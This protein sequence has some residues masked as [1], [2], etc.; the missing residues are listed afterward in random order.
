MTDRAFFALALD[1]LARRIQN[2]HGEDITGFTDHILARI[3]MG[4]G[5]YGDH[6]YLERD[7]LAE[8][9]DEYADGISYP[10]FEL[11]KLR[12]AGQPIP[13]EVAA[14]LTDAMACSAQ[15]HLKVRQAR[16][17]LHSSDQ[18]SPVQ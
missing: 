15:A 6:A 9:S 14:L 18:P 3:D 16:R 10:L 17:L 13:Y 11:E 4:A 1:H 8:A 2:T 5:Q 12:A 7:N